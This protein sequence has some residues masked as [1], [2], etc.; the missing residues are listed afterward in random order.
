MLDE[1]LVLELLDAKIRQTHWLGEG[2]GGSG[3]MAAVTMA[4]LAI[5]EQQEIEY[6]GDPCLKIT[7]SY[8]IDRQSE[9]GGESRFFKNE[10]ILDAGGKILTERELEYKLYDL[11]TGEEIDQ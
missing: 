9:F 6:K 11:L 4:A 2:T 10:A 3:H 8:N 5:E 1:N 7:Y